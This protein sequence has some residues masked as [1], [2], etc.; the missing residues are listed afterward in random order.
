ML[1]SDQVFATCDALRNWECE[2]ILAT[3]F[4][5]VALG[6]E[7]QVVHE[8]EH[9]EPVAIAIVLLNTARGL[10]HVDLHWSRMFNLG[11]YICLKADGLARLDSEDF[12]V[13]ATAFGTGVASHDGVVY[14][15]VSE[16]WHK[17]LGVSADVLPLSGNLTIDDQMGKGVM[18]RGEEG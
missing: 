12:G 11:L 4:P 2:L 18:G 8:L 3:N 9:L 1:N 6:S 15:I 14:N 5:V 7:R 13:R 16:L 10:G 17:S